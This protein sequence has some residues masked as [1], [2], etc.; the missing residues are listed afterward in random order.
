MKMLIRNYSKLSEIK[1]IYNTPLLDLI[2]EAASVHRQHKAYA[3]VQ[4]SSLISIKTGGC[5]EDCGYCPQAARY[6][7]D[8]EVHPL[9]TV[10]KVKE[11]ASI[12]KA[13]GASRLCMGAAWREVRDNKDFDRVLEMVSEV[14]NMGMEVCCTLG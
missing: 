8:I 6:H 4:V 1:T 13:N 14:N 10:E 5:S 7:T 9:M 11:R 2:F 12:A 3:E